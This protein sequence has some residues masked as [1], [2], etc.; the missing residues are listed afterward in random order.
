[1]NTPPKN[2]WAKLKVLKDSRK[3]SRFL[4]ET[5]RFSRKALWESIEQYGNVMLKPYHGKSGYGII[6]VTPLEKNRYAVQEENKI[7]IMDGK[8][9]VFTQ[10]KKMTR[11]QKYMIQRRVHLAEI[12]KRPFDIKVLVQ[13]NRKQFPWKVTDMLAVVAEKDYVITNVTTTILPVK[14]AITQ[15][16]LKS[17]PKRTL[18]KSI[19]KVCLLAAKQLGR[20]YPSQN[21]ICFDI[22]LDHDTKIWII[23]ANFKPSQKPFI[24]LRKKY[25]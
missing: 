18:I 13:R 12:D 17:A 1:M 24:I 6:Q 15:S 3:L 23:E 4:P 22:G 9:T 16:L 7:I 20:Y 10:L 5:R 2:K 14:S 21:M 19:R 25:R 8:I 11:L